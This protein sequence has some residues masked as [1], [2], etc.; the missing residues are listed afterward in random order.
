MKL[1]LHQ[2]QSP[3]HRPSLSLFCLKLETYLRVNQLKY[4]VQF[5]MPHSMPHSKL[6]CLE[7]NSKL[8]PDSHECIRQLIHL[9]PQCDLNKGLS[10]SQLSD[11]FAYLSMIED[12][13]YPYVLCERWLDN[14]KLNRP[15]LQM[16][17]NNNKSNLVAQGSARHDKEKRQERIKDHLQ[18]L[19]NRLQNG[20]FNGDAPTEVD[21]SIFG[22]IA[23]TIDN[24]TTPFTRSL[25]LSHKSIKNHCLKM[26]DY[27]PEYTK[28]KEIVK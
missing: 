16:I 11:S 24:Q 1:I 14:D 8:I 13:L 27:F 23:T 7:I 12:G 19:E 3:S 28:L 6:P 10:K 15:E 2:F 22:L 5:A 21:C 18:F 26:L 25:L 4:S 9:N 17:R 20:Y